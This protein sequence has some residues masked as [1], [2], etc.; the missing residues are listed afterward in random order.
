MLEDAALL[1]E[2]M[3]AAALGQL[4]YATLSRIGS[5]ASIIS[6]L[7]AVYH[8]HFS[9]TSASHRHQLLSSK[10]SMPGFRGFFDL[11]FTEYTS[12]FFR[13]LFA[14]KPGSILSDK[15]ASG[16]QRHRLRG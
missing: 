5:L 9:L 1:N 13:C 6:P 10:A 8:Y 7:L 16:V 4:G 3:L 11:S 12:F 15:S 14:V 2:T